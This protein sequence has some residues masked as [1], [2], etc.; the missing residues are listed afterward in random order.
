[1]TP[2]KTK[3][4]IIDHQVLDNEASKAYRRHVTDIWK[5]TYQLVPPMFIAAT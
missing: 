4:H 5:A 3:G 1:M 2:L